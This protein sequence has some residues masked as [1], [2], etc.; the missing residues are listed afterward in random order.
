MGELINKVWK[1]IGE[2]IDGEAT[3]DN[4]GYS[5]SISSD[6]NTVAIGAP[7]NDGKGNNSGHVR[8]YQYNSS[9]KKWTQIGEDIDGK[10]SDF[11]SGNSV[12]LSTNCTCGFTRVAIRRTDK[13]WGD[14]I[15]S[16]NNVFISKLYYLF[17]PLIRLI[18]FPITISRFFI[19]TLIKS[20][21]SNN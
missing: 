15:Y 14:A 2:D 20:F 3:N 19:R 10:A 1:Q 4:S 21:K 12:S 16:K 18:K 11:W 6:G 17:L 13:G 9:N 8:I 5:V 7:F